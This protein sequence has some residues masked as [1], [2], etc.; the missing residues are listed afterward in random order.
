MLLKCHLL[1]IAFIASAL[2]SS[3]IGAAEPDIRR[4]ATVEVI[5]RVI[6]AIVNIS[7]KTVIQRKG[8]VYD[9]WR[10]NW[11]PFSQDLPPEYSAGSG[12]I[13]DEE[14]YVLTNAH[15]IEQAAEVTVKLHDNRTLRADLVVG[16]RRTDVALLKLRGKPGEKFPYARLGGDD[17]LFL[18]ETVLA[19]GN[20][21]GLGESVSK[22][23]LSSKSRRAKSGNGPLDVEDWLQT[24]AAINPG[25]SGGPLVNLRG[26]VI[27]LNVAV[28][29]EGQ[30]IGFA[31]PVKRISESLAEI[32][33]PEM[34]KSLWFGATFQ[35]RPAEISVATVE[36]GSPADK[37][38]LRPGDIIIRINNK[39]P[40]STMALNRELIAANDKQDVS[41]TVQR[42]SDR[43]T[44]SV[45]L[46]P[47]V[48]Y[49]N[50]GYIR[51][52]IGAVVDVLN[53]EIAA[54]LGLE[55]GGFAI[56]AVDRGSPAAEAG[57]QRGFILEGIDGQALDSITGAARLLSRHKKGTTAK[58]QVVAPRPPRRGVLEVIVR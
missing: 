27:G 58:L 50:A 10:D 2:I 37:G 22:G 5:E 42:G 36:P 8:Y 6:P 17:D 31:I 54:R 15:V 38:G 23:I 18:G 24:D 13:I 41:F 55:S 40:R 46:V 26:E 32:Y 4:D 44:V 30:G 3:P 16:T 28:Y 7:S 39:L 49:F 9:W 33:T 21:F 34:V 48:N 25:N 45:R 35:S 11:A 1:R 57:I 29:K 43:R 20:P 52:R 12:V 19:V 51:D 53:P 14:G 47:E 56:T